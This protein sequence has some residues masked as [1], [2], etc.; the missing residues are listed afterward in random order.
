M[1]GQGCRLQAWRQPDWHT[2]QTLDDIEII[3]RFDFP[4]NPASIRLTW[5]DLNG[6]SAPEVWVSSTQQ[7]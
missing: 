1:R 4:C 3:G 2:I 6:D 7:F 5:N